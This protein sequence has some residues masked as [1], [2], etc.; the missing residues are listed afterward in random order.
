MGAAITSGEEDWPRLARRSGGSNATDQ[1]EKTDSKK[2]RL[3]RD[4]PQ[5]EGHWL[6]ILLAPG[7][8]LSGARMTAG[9]PGG[10]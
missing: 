8:V 4:T 2:R 6:L 7:R 3:F 9:S 10:G 1:T 5:A